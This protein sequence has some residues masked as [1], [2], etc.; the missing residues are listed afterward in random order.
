V[1]Q[2]V[3]YILENKAN[4][5]RY[6]GKTTYSLAER[7][8]DHINTD[9][10]IGNALRKNGIDGFTSQQIV[11][12]KDE[13]DYW[14]KYFIGKLNTVYP[15]G[16]NLTF[17][18]DGGTKSEEA[19]LRMSKPKSPEGRAAIALSNND[20]E[21]LRKASERFLNGGS[22]ANRP[23]VQQKMSETAKKNHLSGIG[24]TGYFSTHTFA[25]EKSAKWKGP[26]KEIVCANP[27]CRKVLK[28]RPYDPRKY[29]NCK[30]MAEDPGRTSKIRE[31]QKGKVLSD[32]HLQ[33][34]KIAQQARRQRESSQLVTLQ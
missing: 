32:S 21:R 3:I 6:V 4:G 26:D 22:P 5:K 15:N 11:Y 10:Y 27:S 33:N 7:L 18:G 19:K 9:S 29:C 8:R 30:C 23:E 14:E 25:G 2:S 24:N 13:L 12:H 1:G 17:G 34:I 31:K 28:V 20:P 16:Y